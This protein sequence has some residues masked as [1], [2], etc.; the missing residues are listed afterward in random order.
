MIAGIETIGGGLVALT[1]FTGNIGFEVVDLK[2][3]IEKY[4]EK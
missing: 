3:I 2:K 4:T 1:R